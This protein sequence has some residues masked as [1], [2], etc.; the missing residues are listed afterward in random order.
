[1]SLGKK[2][3]SGVLH[4]LT[5]PLSIRFYKGR[6]RAKAEWGNFKP[7]K[8][9]NLGEVSK[10]SIL[11]L[12][13]WYPDRPELSGE[14]GVSYLIQADDFV[15]LFDVGLNQKNEH[16]SPLLRNMEALGVDLAKVNQVVISHAHADHIGGVKATRQKSIC[17]SAEDVDLSGKRI[18]VPVPLNHPTGEIKLVKGPAKIADG[19]ATLGPISSQLFFFGWTPEQ[20]LGVNVKG[21]GIVLIVGCGHQGL[22]RIIKRAGDIF[23]APLYGIVGGLHFPATE[24]RFKTLGIPFQQ[25]LGTGRLPWDPITMDYVREQIDLLRALDLKI[26]SLSAHDSCDK[27]IEAFRDSFPGSFKDLRVGL[28]IEIK[29]EN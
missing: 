5:A 16:P 23:D 19:V 9:D 26:I 6:K 4:L 1:M 28:P 21:K 14:A 12:I 10:L 15:I 18:L 8:L 7:R 17:I 29:R 22:S 24:S 2:I 3:T 27:A 20:A 11:P 25:I 13:D